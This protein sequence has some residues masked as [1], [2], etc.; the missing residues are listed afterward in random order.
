M[1]NKT[2][3]LRIGLCGGLGLAR[4]DQHNMA[5]SVSLSAE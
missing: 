3:T 1:S 2:N 4:G 5:V